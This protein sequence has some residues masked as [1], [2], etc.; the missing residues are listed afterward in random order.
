MMGNGVS[1]SREHS[2]GHG[3]RPHHS[4][5]IPSPS[6]H[7]LAGE[8]GDPGEAK[9]VGVHEDVLHE[10]VRGAAVL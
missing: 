9:V 2:P 7:S 6:Q 4:P 1:R 8:E 5:G 3:A 10:E